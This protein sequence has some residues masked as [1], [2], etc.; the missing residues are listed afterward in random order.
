MC[1]SD[2]LYYKILAY[3][4][5]KIN[6]I[7]ILREGKGARAKKSKRIIIVREIDKNLKYKLIKPFTKDYNKL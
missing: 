3:I 4:L 1:S 7:S 6:I 5:I 2:L